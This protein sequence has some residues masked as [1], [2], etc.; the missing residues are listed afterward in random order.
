MNKDKQKWTLHRFTFTCIRILATRKPSLHANRLYFFRLPMVQSCR[1]YWEVE[2]WG[3]PVS[4]DGSQQPQHR[5]A[6]GEAGPFWP[7][8]AGSFEQ[9]WW[10]VAGPQTAVCSSRSCFQ[11][12]LRTECS[13]WRRTRVQRRQKSR[14]KRTWAWSLCWKWTEWVWGEW[15]MSWRQVVWRWV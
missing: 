9:W 14:R 8:E 12:T 4:F 7:E 2:C 13:C 5:Q 11:A 6:Q 3:F 1:R 15:R 10:G